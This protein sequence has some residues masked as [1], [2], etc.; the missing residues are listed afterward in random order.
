MALTTFPIVV[1]I[2]T[3]S[4]FGG[5]G[6][7]ARV[8]E[9]LASYGWA[10]NYLGG[11]SVMIALVLYILDASYWEG[12]MIQVKRVLL[13]FIVFGV[14]LGCLFAASDYPSAPMCVFVVG[15]VAYFV[16]LRKVFFFKQHPASFFGYLSIA[17]TSI[18]VIVCAAFLYWMTSDDENFWPGEG[19]SLKLD[20]NIAMGCDCLLNVTVS[21]EEVPCV[22]SDGEA[23]EECCINAVCLAGYLLWLHR[24]CRASFR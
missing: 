22:V 3:F 13:I 16:I 14:C 11:G 7:G 2:L 9:L 19:N 24:L 5:I 17:M 20:H 15:S 6:H 8:H 1:F 12:K 4:D 10:R 21:G 18:G 23:Y